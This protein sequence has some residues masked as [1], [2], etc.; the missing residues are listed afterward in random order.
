MLSEETTSAKTWSGDVFGPLEKLQE[1]PC[2]LG[3]KWAGGSGQLRWG[4][5]CSGS[6][7]KELP[8]LK[9]QAVWV[10]S[11]SSWVSRSSRR[12]SAS[13]SLVCCWWSQWPFQAP[14][15]PCISF[16]SQDGG[17]HRG[18]TRVP[19]PT[20]LYNWAAPEVILQKAATVKSDIYSFSVIVQEILTG[21]SE[22][23]LAVTEV[24]VPRLGSFPLKS[25][26][27]L[28]ECRTQGK[29]TLG[30]LFVFMQDMIPQK[31]FSFNLFFKIQQSP[32][33][34]LSMVV[35]LIQGEFLN[36]LLLS[37]LRGLCEVPLK[38]L[39]PFSFL[40][41]VEVQLIYSIVPISAVTQLHTCVHSFNILSHYGL[42]Q[43]IE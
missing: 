24:P 29:K 21:G 20:Q 30:N 19:L 25:H 11:G 22:S 4:R 28:W 33:I 40:I 9:Q 36:W 38:N 10:A 7:S 34:G 13:V 27:V 41:F 42:S 32:P 17:A 39:F 35:H 43:G 12:S 5:A 6:N 31:S 1:G 23:T 14:A 3:S 2:D 18:L 37:V 8:A 16:C 26:L 15:P